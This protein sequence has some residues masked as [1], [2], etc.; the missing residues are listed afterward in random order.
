M[1]IICRLQKLIASQLQLLLVVMYSYYHYYSFSGHPPKNWGV[2]CTISLK[3]QF[4]Y[5]NHHHRIPL[6][7]YIIRVRPARIPRVWS[8]ATAPRCVHRIPIPQ[9]IRIRQDFSCPT[10]N[11]SSLPLRATCHPPPILAPDRHHRPKHLRRCIASI[12]FDSN[13]QTKIID[14]IT[15]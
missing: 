4:R 11:P 15:Y 12:F 3:P 14:T 6:S 1:Y 10:F 13:W 5:R 7:A 2:Y 8:K 9:H